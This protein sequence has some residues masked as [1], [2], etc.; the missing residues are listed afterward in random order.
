M[1]KIKLVVF[2]CYGVTLFGGYPLTMKK[3]AKMLTRDWKELHEVFYTKYFN[4]A[5]MG[6]I[7]QE[8]AWKKPIDELG[9]DI[10]VE[11]VKKIHYDLFRLNDK[12]VSFINTLKD[13][14]VVLVTKNTPEQLK[15][16]E[17]LIPFIRYFDAVINTYDL[18]LPKASKE[19]QEYIMNKFCVSADEIIYIDDQEENLVQAKKLGIH[20]I[21]YSDFNRF[22]REFKKLYR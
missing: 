13:V 2:D 10:T 11:E 14:K 8:E 20:I 7:T 15:D 19:T 3:V 21:L 16:T 6:K 4:L 12:I 9:L 1:G 22:M 5:A 18:N 17:K